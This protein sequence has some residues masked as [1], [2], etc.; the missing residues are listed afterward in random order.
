MNAGVIF[1]SILLSLFISV[2]VSVIVMRFGSRFAL[3]DNPNYRSSHS[4]PTPRGG[5]IGIWLAFM[6][7]GI[8]IAKYIIFSIIAG[9]VGLLG[10]LE[11][12][13]GFSSKKRLFI[14]FVI[15][16]LSVYLFLGLP[17]SASAL[18]LSLFWIVFI[19][20]TANFY[21]FM[22]GINGIAGLS[23]IVAFGLIAFFSLIIN[24][25]PEIV[26]MSIALASGCLGFLPYNF[27]KA[28]VFMGDVGSVFLGFVFA[29]FVLKLS[30]NVSMFLCLIMFLCTF[31]ADAVLTIFYRWRMHK[32]LME[33]HRSHLYQYMSNELGLAHWRVSSIYVITQFVFGTL[34]LLAYKMGLVWQLAIIAIF[35]ILFVFSYKTSKRT[36]PCIK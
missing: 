31:Y 4:N 26:L 29:S 16:A 33:A 15:S 35:G 32:P 12:R 25:D 10:L 30:I 19:T 36:K 28:K 23:G 11:D 17:A 5:G 1:F 6:I 8:F 2:F 27:P 14:Q 7:V 34:S 20:G 21:N 18:A 22:D 3:V 24:R 9:A 13:F